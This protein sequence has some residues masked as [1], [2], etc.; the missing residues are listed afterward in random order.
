MH[1]EFGAAA[2]EHGVVVEVNLSATLMSPKYPDRF[3]RQ[4][5]DYLAALRQY[6]LR[7]SIATDCHAPVYGTDFRVAEEILSAVGFRN[8]DLW[9][10]PPRIEGGA[11]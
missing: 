7:F 6:G 5:A 8:D 9:T 2:A 10:L 1:D 11:V 4:Y 3:K